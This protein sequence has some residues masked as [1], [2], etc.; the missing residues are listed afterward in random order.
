VPLGPNALLTVAGRTSG[1]PRSTPLAIIEHEGRRWVWSPWGDVN[2]VRNLRT[3][4][5]A[6]IT[7]RGRSEV[8]AATELDAG[9]RVWFFR[10]VLNP[11]ARA[12]PF[13]VQFI[14]F[15]DGVKLGDPVAAADGR[16]VFELRAP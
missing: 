10:D 16:T 2:W 14:R 9:E 8:V 1:V 12:I 6:T 15:V 11:V 13:G 3:S 5:T 7:V 4:G